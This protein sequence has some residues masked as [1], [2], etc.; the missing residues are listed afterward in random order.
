MGEIVGLELE[1]KWLP[2]RG[3]SKI[4]FLDHFSPSFLDQNGKIS[5][6]FHFDRVRLG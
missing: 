1:E 6:I 5:P 3:I 4:F 2:Q